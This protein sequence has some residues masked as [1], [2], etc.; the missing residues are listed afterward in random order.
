MSLVYSSN[1]NNNKYLILKYNTMI[2]VFEKKH[3][4]FK[5]QFG[6]NVLCKKNTPC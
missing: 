3:Y 6:F 5:I 2:F 4:S 1:P